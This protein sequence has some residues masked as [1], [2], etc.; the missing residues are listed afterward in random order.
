MRCYHS[1]DFCIVRAVN[2]FPEYAHLF[3]VILEKLYKESSFLQSVNQR[4][5]IK[6]IEELHDNIFTARSLLLSKDID[7]GE[8]RKIISDCENE[9]Y[10][11]KKQTRCI[12]YIF[13]SIQKQD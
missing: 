9:D 2:P 8:Y 5:T 10:C 7:A 1:E 4:H 6:R 11:S 3:G 12:S 13:S